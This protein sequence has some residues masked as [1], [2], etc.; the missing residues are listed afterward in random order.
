MKLGNV[1]ISQYHIV[2]DDKEAGKAIDGNLQ[3]VWR[4]EGLIPLVVDL[5]SETEITGFSYAPATDENLD[6][7]IY[8]Y[9][10]YVSNVE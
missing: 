5:G 7:T 8:K 6:G 1:P 2:G 10:F 4:T 3:S 9:N